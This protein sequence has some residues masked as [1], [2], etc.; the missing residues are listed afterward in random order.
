MKPLLQFFLAFFLSLAFASCVDEEE[1]DDTPTGNFEALWKIIDE[2][3]CFFDYKGEEY[4]LDWNAV[5]AKYRARV[6][7]R[8]QSWYDFDLAAVDSASDYLCLF[9]ARH[10]LVR[11]SGIKFELTGK[12]VRA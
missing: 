5:H 3:Y 4:G 6:N 12:S 9:A 7:D 1:F 8:S 2:R 10:V 11:F